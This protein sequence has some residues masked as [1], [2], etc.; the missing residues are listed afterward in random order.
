MLGSGIRIFFK[1]TEYFSL[2]MYKI[3]TM[4][5]SQLHT[6]VNSIEKKK[7]LELKYMKFHPI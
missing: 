4:N 1:N 6:V 3:S 2:C 7:L 5:T